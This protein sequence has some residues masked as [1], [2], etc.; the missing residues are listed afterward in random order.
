MPINALAISP[1][2]KSVHAY[3]T[4]IKEVWYADDATA[5]GSCEKLREW[6]DTLS[7]ECPKH[8]YFPKSSKTYLVVKPEFVDKARTALSGINVNISPEGHRHLGAVIGLQEFRKIYVK[9]KV[10][11]WCIALK[12][13]HMAYSAFIRGV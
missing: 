6:W 10:K 2:I 12:H 7:R 3:H 1:L 4:D 13:P 8:G 5:A 11:S 9:Y